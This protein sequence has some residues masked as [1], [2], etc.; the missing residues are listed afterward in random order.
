MVDRIDHRLKEALQQRQDQ[1]DRQDWAFAPWFRSSQASAVLD[2]AG[3]GKST[4][5]QVAVHKAIDMNANVV[6]A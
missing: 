2:P 3:S 1:D 5:V 4:A 6:I